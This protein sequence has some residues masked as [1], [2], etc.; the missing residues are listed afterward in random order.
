M[1]VIWHLALPS[2]DAWIAAPQPLVEHRTRHQ[3]RGTFHFVES[4]AIIRIWCVAKLRGISMDANDVTVFS[5]R[6]LD[7]LY[8]K[9]DSRLK[10]GNLMR[11]LPLGVVGH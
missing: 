4:T 1:Q 11:Q 3:F 5:S 6:H 10:F 7:I 2:E 8:R 9:A